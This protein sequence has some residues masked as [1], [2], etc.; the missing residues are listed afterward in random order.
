MLYK[1]NPF[2]IYLYTVPTPTHINF[3]FESRSQT[4]R[5]FEIGFNLK[6]LQLEEATGDNKWQIEV[7]AGGRV[8][9]VMRRTEEKAGFNFKVKIKM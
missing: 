1:K 7:P 9:R 6:G 4:K 3:V 5:V 2:D 8:V